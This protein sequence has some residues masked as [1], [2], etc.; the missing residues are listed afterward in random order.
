MFEELADLMVGSNWSGI[1]ETRTLLFLVVRSVGVA[2]QHRQ[3]V[4][5]SAHKRL[6]V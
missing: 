3:A 6:S 2:M 4:P 5:F 1:N